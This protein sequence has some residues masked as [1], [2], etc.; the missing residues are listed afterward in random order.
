[1]KGQHR[2]KFKSRSARRRPHD[3]A[4]V[5]ES[6]Q[7][8]LDISGGQVIVGERELKIARALTDTEKH[9]RD[10]SL[11]SLQDWLASN[12]ENLGEEDMD[13]LWKALFYCIWMADKRPIITATIRNVVDLTDLAGWKY[14]QALFKC[15]MREWFGIDRHRVDKLYELV[16]AALVKCVDIVTQPDGKEQFLGNLELFL[17]LLQQTIFDQ[18]RK[19]GLGLALHIL[20]VY[21]ERVFSPI[22]Q[23][24]TKLPG[25]EIHKVFHS[26]LEPLLSMI[27]SSQGHLLA[28]GKRIQERILERLVDFLSAM[29]EL[30]GKARRDMVQRVSKRVFAVAANKTTSDDVRAGLYE[31]RMDLKMFVD[32]YE[33]KV[34]EGEHDAVKETGKKVARKGGVKTKAKNGLDE[35][36]KGMHDDGADK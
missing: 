13:R 23:R 1:M 12:A 25:N 26:L 34:T 22:M 30:S 20:D 4:K 8:A 35:A 3:K 18:A 21:M 29:E 36:S 7:R 10:A 27:G 6:V 16:T 32:E 31:L 9:V 28:I 19:G 15:L 5:I 24:G 14:M 11:T 33:E 2:I 17:Q